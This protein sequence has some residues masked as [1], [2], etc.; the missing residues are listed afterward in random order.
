MT[1]SL[2][3]TAT[4]V[5]HEHA[6]VHLPDHG[7]GAP[8]FVNGLAGPYASLRPVMPLVERREGGQLTVNVHDWAGRLHFTGAG[9]MDEVIQVFPSKLDPD[10][11]TAFEAL[12]RMA[13]ALPDIA[14]RLGYP[15]EVLAS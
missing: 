4:H 5:V 14:A 1:A 9:G 2:P 7:T 12:Q 6:R 3:D 13:D 8:L 15:T 10:P 11:G